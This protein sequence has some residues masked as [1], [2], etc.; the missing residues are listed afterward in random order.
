MCINKYI[1]FYVYIQIER[2]SKTLYKY[3]YL[4]CKLFLLQPI[5]LR[6]LSLKEQ[7]NLFLFIHM[8]SLKPQHGFY[9]F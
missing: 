7:S 6:I 9:A 4:H 2:W 1:Y 3:K 8:M 5:F